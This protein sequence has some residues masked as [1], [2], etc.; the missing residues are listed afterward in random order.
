MPEI[1]GS[2][3][4]EGDPTGDTG[5]EVDAA[6]SGY[7]PPADDQGVEDA[8]EQA[9]DAEAPDQLAGEDPALQE[10]LKNLEAGYTKKY[11]ALAEE[12]RAFEGE[13]EA[14]QRMTQ[15]A[16][17]S[18]TTENPEENP[19]AQYDWDAVQPEVKH[20]AERTYLGEQRLERIEQI[21]AN[22]VVP[23]I[24]EQTQDKQLAAIKAEYGEFDKNELLATAKQY[25][26][27]VPLDLIAAKLFQ[28]KVREEAAAQ[29]YKNVQTKRA[30]NATTAGSSA[31][32][33]EPSVDT[34]KWS[35]KDFFNH[36]KKTGQRL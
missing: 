5:L 19:W 8:G 26:K 28:T 30:A 12:K 6:D 1:D 4:I 33:T 32:K 21:L 20:V 17:P 2:D 31:A 27:G 15:Q 22:M 18:Q 24:E 34:S 13:R 7:T 3:Q 29:T 9:E 11:Q 35:V 25:P 14:Y 10:K 36:A 23:Q 16:P